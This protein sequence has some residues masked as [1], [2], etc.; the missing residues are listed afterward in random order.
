MDGESYETEGRDE[1]CDSSSDR[2]RSRLVRG[3]GIDS[4]EGKHLNAAAIAVYAV[5][6]SRDC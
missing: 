5:R 4:D 1:R 6:R 3:L 2:R